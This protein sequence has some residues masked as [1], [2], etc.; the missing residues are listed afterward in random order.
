MIV[1]KAVHSRLLELRT[2]RV[3][4]YKKK[5]EDSLRT[6][7]ELRWA[8]HDLFAYF[9]NHRGGYSHAESARIE[10]IRRMIPGAKLS[11][12]D[13]ENA[14]RGVLVNDD[15]ILIRGDARRLPLA[16][17][18]VQCIVTSPPYW[19][20]RKYAGAQELTWKLDAGGSKLDPASS[21]QPQASWARRIRIGAHHRNVRRAHGRNPARVPP[22][23]PLRRRAL[24]EYRR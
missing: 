16:D 23:A 17:E 2:T 7:A 1:P 5:W 10:E 3:V 13:R 4:P 20:F 22:R 18:S 8:I 9:E 6:I 12:I 15:L 11:R 24:L 21:I 14:A 19:G